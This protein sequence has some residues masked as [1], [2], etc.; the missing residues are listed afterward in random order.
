[1]IFNNFSVL[2]LS[3]DMNILSLMYIIYQKLKSQFLVVEIKLLNFGIDQL[4][5]VDEQLMIIMKNG[6]DVVILIKN[7]FSLLVMIKKY[8]YFQLIN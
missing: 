8:L 1:M 7:I 4:L 3:L 5:T 2:K 6:F